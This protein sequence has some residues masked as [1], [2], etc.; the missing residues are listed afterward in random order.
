M[1]VTRIDAAGKACRRPRRWMY[2]MRGGL[3]A[4][5]RPPRPSSSQSAIAAGFCTSSESGPP[6]IV[7]PPTSSLKITPPARGARSRTTN[8]RPRRWSS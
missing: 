8:E 5:S 1:V 4:T 3:V 6:S 2:A 7:K